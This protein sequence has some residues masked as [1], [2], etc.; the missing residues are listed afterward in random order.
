MSV[1]TAQTI[2]LKI[3]DRTSLDSALDAAV[4]ELA[5]QARTSRCGILVTR[6]GPNVF[7]LSVNPGIPFGTTLEQ[8]TWE[9]TGRTKR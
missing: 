6:S 4:E 9:T 2:T 1:E 5:S 3:W 7:T 8:D